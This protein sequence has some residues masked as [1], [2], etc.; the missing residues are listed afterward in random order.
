ME[1]IKEVLNNII[2]NLIIYSSIFLIFAI[3][4][5]SLNILTRGT[6]WIVLILS[7]NN[8]KNYYWFICS[9]WLIIFSLI[10]LIKG[11]KG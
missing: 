5:I 6:I 2:I 3:A 1:K 7:G 10:I 8:I 11:D 4:G 9:I